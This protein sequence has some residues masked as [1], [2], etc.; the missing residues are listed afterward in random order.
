MEYVKQNTRRK[1]PKLPGLAC[2]LRFPRRSKCRDLVSWC[3]QIGTDCLGYQYCPGAN[4]LVSNVRGYA[5]LVAQRHS[6]LD[7]EHTPEII[8]TSVM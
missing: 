8:R 5:P 4:K 1:I 6:F 7:R 2:T 3:K